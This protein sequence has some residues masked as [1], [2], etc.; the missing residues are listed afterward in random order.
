MIQ[1]ERVTTSPAETQ[2][3]GRSFAAIF[4]DKY[5][6]Q[7]VVFALRGE[8]G[9][10]KTQ[11]VKGLAQGLGI[12]TLITS[13]SYTLVNEYQFLATD[14][15]VPFVHLDAWRLPDLNDLESVGWS[16]FLA[17]NAV[18]ALE[19]AP[20]QPATILPANTPAIIID[21]SY[22]QTEEERCLAWKIFD[23]TPFQSE[24]SA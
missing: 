17:S 4:Q 8:L 21:F 5:G 1:T 22:G 16:R 11:F 12:E 3:I 23:Q 10:G 9:T 18:I 7:P 15:A 6:H 13:P 14:Q 20:E 2:T 24:A 19:W